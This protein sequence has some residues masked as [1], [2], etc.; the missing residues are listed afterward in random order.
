MT[1]I[2]LKI[3]SLWIRQAVSIIPLGLQ[4]QITTVSDYSYK[5][6]DLKGSSYSKIACLNNSMTNFLSQTTRLKAAQKIIKIITRW[7]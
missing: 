4:S 3:V 2:S 7:L 6:P 5:N 1:K